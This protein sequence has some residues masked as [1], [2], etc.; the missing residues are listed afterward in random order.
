M[1]LSPRSA[2]RRLIV[3]VAAA[4]A[5]LA[6]TS[7]AAAAIQFNGAPGTAAAP[8][9]LGPYAMTPFPAD[10]RPVGFTV[11][12]VPSP[13]GGSVLLG[14]ARTHRRVGI[15]W[16]SSWSHGA[17]PDVYGDAG[18]TSQVLTMPPG[19]GAFYFYA[20][21]N[22]QTVPFTFQ[23]TA[24]DG[25]TSGPISITGWP[26]GIG[27]EG[28]RYFGF[29]AT[30]GDTLA[31]IT[32]TV[33]AGAL[34]FAVGEFGIA[35]AVT[36][37]DD[38]KCYRG[39]AAA[40]HAA[41]GDPVTLQDR[42]G[43]SRATIGHVLN[44]CNSVDKNGEGV[45]VPA[46]NFVGYQLI[47]RVSVSATG[48]FTR[49]RVR[50][51]NEF[52]EVTLVVQRPDRLMVAS[53]RALAPNV[54]DPL[55]ASV[56]NYLCYKVYSSSAFTRRWVSL[57]DAFRTERTEVRKPRMMCN[58]VS[59]NGAPIANGD[60]HLVCYV[61]RGAARPGRWSVNTVN[62]FGTTAIVADRVRHLCVPSAQTVL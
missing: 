58:P 44:L 15:N 18:Q 11:S 53:A 48:R 39:A 19:T 55:T 7:A 5:A 17:Q 1:R 47:D 16:T 27:I 42:F 21:P 12:D 60:E 61:A 13:L 14:P 23:A 9:T 32:V 28:A 54:P 33:G 49:R 41:S 3:L 52:G 31:T 8:P 22:L 56:D 57:A 50:M 25:T 46:R 36:A 2:T 45:N 35:A 10:T 4:T 59:T 20:E 51:E 26:I 62:G 34:G 37:L 30:G 6:V 29:Y 43:N 40:S 38:F 24:H